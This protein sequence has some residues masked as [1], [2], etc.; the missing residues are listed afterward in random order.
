MT[1]ARQGGRAAARAGFTLLEVMLAMTV[2]AMVAA[3]C[4]GAFHLGIRAVERGEVA[5]VTA[6]RLRVATDVIIRQIK[7]TVAYAVRNDDEEVFPYFVGSATSLAFVT[8][9][10]LHGGGGLAQVT[11]QVIDDPPRLVMAESPFFSPDSLGREPVGKPDASATVL[12]DGFRS[13]KFEYMMND[14][15]ETEWRGAWDAHEDEMLPAA[16]RIL[17][18]GLPGM[19]LDTWGQEIPIMFAAFGENTGET[20]DDDEEQLEDSTPNPNGTPQQQEASGRGD[21][22]DDNDDNDEGGDE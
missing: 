15:V 20:S 2:L 19:E 22:N 4:Y 1:D 9:A 21:D 5:V 10:G 17:I 3:I 18:E 14:G 8:T 7:S 12:L 16:V 11:Y 13:L 6:Q